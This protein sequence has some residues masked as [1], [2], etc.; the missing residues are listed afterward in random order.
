MLP[1]L[2]AYRLRILA[3]GMLLCFG[4]CAGCKLFSCAYLA[5]L[6]A[7]FAEGAFRR[8]AMQPG[9]L[10]LYGLLPQLMYGAA[11]LLSACT[12]WAAPLWSAA[13]VCAGAAAGASGALAVAML[14]G[15][16]RGASLLGVCLVQL[17]AASLLAVYAPMRVGAHAC[18]EDERTA[19]VQRVCVGAILFVALAAGCITINGAQIVRAMFD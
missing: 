10:L 6:E 13:V 2:K 19:H 17:A 12:A 3:V 4:I 11:M 5:E 7:Y 16:L 1:P 9:R 18:A 14:R 8:P 15:G